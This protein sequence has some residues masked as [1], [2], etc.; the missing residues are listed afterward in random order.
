MKQHIFFVRY[1]LTKYPLV[2]NTGP[3]DSPLHPIDGYEHGVA[4]SRRIAGMPSPPDVVYSS[5]LHRAI[6]TSQMIVH[7]IGKTTKSIR[8]EEGLIEWLTPS[9]RLLIFIYVYI[10]KLFVSF[11]LFT[12]C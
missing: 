7:A 6:S 2:E 5:S 8:V 12:I 1:G 4:I 11:C 3:Y 10:A 9:V